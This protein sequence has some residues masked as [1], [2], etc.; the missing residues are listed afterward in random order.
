[1]P[2]LQYLES[3]L[4]NFHVAPGNLRKRRRVL[5]PVRGRRRCPRPGRTAVRRRS[6]QTRAQHRVHDLGQFRAEDP[7]VPIKPEHKLDV[8]NGAVEIV[9]KQEG[10]EPIDWSVE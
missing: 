3:L 1:M 7:D 4:R 5:A 2:G 10:L 6:H 9:L 8:A